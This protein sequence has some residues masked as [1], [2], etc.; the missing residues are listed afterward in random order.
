MNSPKYKKGQRLSFVFSIGKD[1]IKS[2]LDDNMVV[3]DEPFEEN[4]IWMY[5]IIGKANPSPENLLEP[6][7]K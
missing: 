5:P 3:A 1:K 6:F 4:N 2:V 7:K